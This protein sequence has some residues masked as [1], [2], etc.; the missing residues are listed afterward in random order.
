MQSF[1][2]RFRS[3]LRSFLAQNVRERR[4][5]SFRSTR[6]ILLGQK[7]FFFVCFF[8][9]SSEKTSVLGEFRVYVVELDF[10]VGREERDVRA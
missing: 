5:L 9:P 7:I 4:N 10:L 2:S 1:F 6:E 3:F 8:L